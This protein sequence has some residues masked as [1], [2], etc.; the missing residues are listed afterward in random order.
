MAR[1]GFGYAFFLTIFLAL[2]P[3]AQ[4]QAQVPRLIHYQGYLANPVGQPVNATE[5]MVFKLYA[6]PAGGAALFAETQSVA[7]SN[8]VFSATIGAVT[9]LS[10]PFDIPYYLG[11]T[12]GAD[13]EMTPRLPVLSSPYALRAA[14]VDATAAL[15]AAQITGTLSTA[16]I[17]DGAV[18]AA[19]LASNGC[20][21]GQVL[22]FSG[23]AW[24]CASDVAGSGTVTSVQTGSGLTGGPITSTGTISADTTFLQRRVT[25]SCPAGQFVR[26]VAGDGT[27]TCGADADNNSGGTVTSVAAGAGISVTGTATVSPVVA[28]ADAGVTTQKILDGNVTKS[29]LSASGGSA[30]QILSTDGSALQWSTASPTLTATINPL[31]NT[32]TTIDSLGVNGEHGA[33]TLGL[34]GLPVL[35]YYD[36]GSTRLKVAKCSTAACTGT[37]TITEVDNAGDVGQ[38]SSIT[39]GVDGSP[40]ISYHD[41]T[42]SQLKFAKCSNPAC[43]AVSAIVPLGSSA[44]FSA[45]PTSITVSADGTPVIS[46]F[47]SAFNLRVAKCS[48][49]LCSFHTTNIVDAVASGG[50]GNSI[51][52]GTD[53]LP[54][55]AYQ[56]FSAGDLKVAKCSNAACTA[57][58]IT[59]VDAANVGQS[60]SITI[61]ADGFPVISYFDSA[62]FDLKVAKCSNAACTAFTL[63]IVDSSGITGQHSSIIIGADG[64][65]AIS[66]QHFGLHAL[67]FVKCGNAA[68]SSGNT[69]STL[70]AGSSD[71][72]LHTSMTLGADGLPVI[73]Y[74]D[75]ANGTLKVLKCSTASC[76]PFARRR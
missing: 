22:K 20:A 32:I 35:S 34:D 2:L 49:A 76:I 7:V 61:G 55:I 24:A 71:M 19:K 67:R 38:R 28:I 6:A 21:A 16:Q 36:S 66:Y 54:V 17:A 29:K 64:L 48:N 13:A 69:I 72:G 4:T 25:G 40:L 39:I 26:A 58:T 15:P 53:G 37:A 44:A 18:S 50:Q 43:T 56:D 59:T 52:L 23:S 65:P 8:G 41:A 31:G 57:S 27:V 12:V 45:S 47:D 70:D 60:A 33:I 11:V 62:N 42:N 30:G 46:Y 3:A 1:S 51:V 74:Q 5:T 10:L 63:S 14:A 9:A 68:C 75:D 73:S